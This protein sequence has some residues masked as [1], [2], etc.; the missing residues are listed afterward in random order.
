MTSSSKKGDTWKAFPWHHGN[1]PRVDCQSLLEKAFMQSV[2]IS[3]K[4]QNAWLVRL[5]RNN[6]QTISICFSKKKNE[7]RYTLDPTVTPIP[8]FQH[9]I[10]HQAEGT[11]RYYLVRGKEFGDIHQL[12]EYYKVYFFE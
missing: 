12:V 9:Y 2:K 4:P 7:D 11:G 8:K 1:I 3:G 6:E 10:V 5:S